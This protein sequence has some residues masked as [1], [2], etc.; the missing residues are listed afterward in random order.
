MFVG[1]NQFLNR[2]F[3][4]TFSFNGSDE[5][6]IRRTENPTDA[7]IRSVVR[8]FQ[9]TEDATVRKKMRTDAWERI[10]MEPLCGRRES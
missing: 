5:T 1:W 7:R 4:F 10:E 6:Q 9:K 3:L 2:I 8:F